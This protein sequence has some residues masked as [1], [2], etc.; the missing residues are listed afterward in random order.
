[1]VAFTGAGISTG[2]GAELPT[3]R[4]KFGVSNQQLKD[5]DF[6]PESVE[7]LQPTVRA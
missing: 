2:A 1:V 6:D 5:E 7:R 4:G 3:I